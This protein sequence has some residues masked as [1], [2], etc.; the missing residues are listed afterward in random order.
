MLT[1]IAG[2]DAAGIA[3]LEAEGVIGTVPVH[4]PRPLDTPEHIA[5]RIERGELSRV[6]ADFDGWREAD[7][8][9]PMTR[10]ALD[11]STGVGASY[12]AKLLAEVGW[13]VVKVEPRDGDPWRTRESRWGAGTGGAFRFVNHGKRS[14]FADWKILERLAAA[15]DVVVGDFSETGCA[16]AELPDDAYEVLA[17]RLATVSVSPFGLRGPKSRWA[18][19]DLIVQAASGLMF[20]TGEWDQPP[21][22][23]PPYAAAMAG[24]LAGG[25]AAL[26]AARVARRGGARQYADVAMLEALV[27]HTYGQATAYA[28]RGEVP[29]RERR[30]KQALRMVPASDRFVYCA[31]GAVA[32]VPMSGVAELLDDPRL[33]A[34][35]FQTAEGRMQ[36]Y[37]EYLDL[38]VPPFQQR[39]AQEWFERAERLHL[40]FALVQTIDDL[41]VCP[42]LGR[43]RCFAT[44]PASRPAPRCRAVRSDWRAGH[45]R[46][47]G[48]HPNVPASTLTR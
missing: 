7:A 33:A 37:D 13:D 2:L 40:T 25:S 32:S 17:P 18:T 35:R 12:S 38:F 30:I 28:Y 36:H 46:Q 21:M 43:V 15:A 8:G 1:E 22:Q 6:D 16:E 10:R 31:P 3:E 20:L 44:R 14:V 47:R 23:L 19:S 26:V 27:G 29:R 41:F 34:D 4:S 5:L 42:Q 9:G 11:L 39:T 45:R 24:G 48:R